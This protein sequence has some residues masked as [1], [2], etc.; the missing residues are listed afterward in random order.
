VDR[1]VVEVAGQL[2]VE[3]PKNR[4]YPGRSTRSARPPGTR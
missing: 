1:K 4:K 2:Y 3:P